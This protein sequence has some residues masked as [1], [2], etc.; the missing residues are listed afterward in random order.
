MIDSCG[1]VHKMPCRTVYKS[2]S[3]FICDLGTVK[4]ISIDV[5]DSDLICC[6]QPQ[7]TVQNTIPS[8]SG[9]QFNCS[10]ITCGIT[11]L[12]PDELLPEHARKTVKTIDWSTVRE[13]GPF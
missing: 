4:L 11:V 2:F 8:P 10:Q 7:A 5:W 1:T 6:L 12:L 3:Y 9:Q 13:R